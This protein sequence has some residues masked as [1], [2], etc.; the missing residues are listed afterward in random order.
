M[1]QIDSS[2][3]KIFLAVAAYAPLVCVYIVVAFY[4]WKEG[5]SKGAPA[6]MHPLAASMG[7]TS[8]MLW[9]LVAPF[10]LLL[11]VMLMGHAG[12]ACWNVGIACLY[13]AGWFYDK[14]RVVLAVPFCV[15][16]AFNIPVGLSFMLLS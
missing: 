15:L 7:M 9:I 1:P 5:L 4:C 14:G 11:L 12:M 10:L 13:T 2:A 16:G 6:G 8:C 3:V